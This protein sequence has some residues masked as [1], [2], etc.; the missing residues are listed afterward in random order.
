MID[1]ARKLMATKTEWAVVVLLCALTVGCGSDTDE[2]DNPTPL[3]CERATVTKFDEC[4]YGTLGR[5][6]GIKEGIE[7]FCASRCT[8]VNSIYVKYTNWSDL[9]FATGLTMLDGQFVVEYNEQLESLDGMDEV[10]EFGA[11]HSR[12]ANNY[13]LR[14]LEG[15]GSLRRVNESFTI[16]YNG[17]ESIQGLE[18]LEEVEGDLIIER[19]WKLTDLKALESLERV[20]EDL[21]VESNEK[22]P[23]CEIDWLVERIDIEGEIRLTGNGAETDADCS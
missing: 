6:P 1:K 8:T 7:D 5:D 17:I 13:K 16:R 4:S 14:N 3:E 22:L 20:G 2:N 11:G 12:I 18:S 19:N 23:R 21:F 10:M 9:S 15:L